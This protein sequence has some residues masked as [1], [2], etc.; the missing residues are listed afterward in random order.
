MAKLLRAGLEI[1]R[2]KEHLL[3]NLFRDADS[4]FDSA[5][6]QNFTGSREL[7]YHGII[8]R[9]LKPRR[10]MRPTLR[11]CQRRFARR[12][13]FRDHLKPPTNGILQRALYFGDSRVVSAAGSKRSRRSRAHQ[14]NSTP[15]TLAA[16]HLRDRLLGD[17]LIGRLGRGRP[18][19]LA[20][21][22]R[23]YYRKPV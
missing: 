21:T 7:R 13:A 18:N 6:S 17:V 8:P 19:P 22:R 15:A 9:L 16:R 23:G 20:P 3:R 14:A 5:A 2:P 11:V 10:T 12:F 1:I 4:C